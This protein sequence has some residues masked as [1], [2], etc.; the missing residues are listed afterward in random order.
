M[1]ANTWIFLSLSRYVCVCMLVRVCACVCVCVRVS[2][3]VSVR[4]SVCVHMFGE[5]RCFGNCQCNTDSPITKSWHNAT[6]RAYFHHLLV[7]ELHRAVSFIEM[8][9]LSR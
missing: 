9:C 3:S 1:H 2:V 8:H 4:V 7:A 5:R 6:S